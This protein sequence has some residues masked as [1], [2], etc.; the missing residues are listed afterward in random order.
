MQ[1]F[2]FPRLIT[3]FHL[4]SPIFHTIYHVQDISFQRVTKN[5]TL[6]C[7]FSC[8]KVTIFQF[9]LARRGGLLEVTRVMDFRHHERIDKVNH[10]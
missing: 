10:A 7:A 4:F 9:S 2:D 8:G 3:I 1:V 5:D 6:S